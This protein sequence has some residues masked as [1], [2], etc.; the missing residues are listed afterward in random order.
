MNNDLLPLLKDFSEL[1]ENRMKFHYARNIHGLSKDEINRCCIDEDKD[2]NYLQRINAI[3]KKLEKSAESQINQAKIMQYA[4]T[5][6]ND[7]TITKTEPDYETQ[8]RDQVAMRVLAVYIPIWENDDVF[9]EDAMYEV[10]DLANAFMAERKKH[11][12]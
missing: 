3:I 7:W 4:K 5:M 9:I 8:L 2:R 10:F 12:P 1:F 11:T 6:N